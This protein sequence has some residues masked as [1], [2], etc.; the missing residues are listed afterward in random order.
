MVWQFYYIATGRSEEW[1]SLQYMYLPPIMITWDFARLTSN[2]NEFAQEQMLSR[3]SSMAVTASVSSS[4]LKLQLHN[5][6]LSAYRL[7]RRVEETTH[8]PGAYPQLD[9]ISWR[10]ALPNEPVA[11]IP[12]DKNKPSNYS[13]KN[14]KR[15]Y[16]A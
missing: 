6:K 8:H 12:E 11:S 5:Y 15:Q 16:H 13:I 3:S 10:M 14:I 2:P 4:T 9:H 1:L 7:L